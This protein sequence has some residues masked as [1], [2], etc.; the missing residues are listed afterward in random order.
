MIIG[1]K[2]EALTP[3]IILDTLRHQ[4]EQ[5][6]DYFTIHAGV[7]RAHLPLLRSRL[8]GIVSRGGS[9]LAKWMIHHGQENP[10]YTLFDEICQIMRRYDVSFSLGD[11]LRPGGL[12]DASDAA[13]FAELATLGELTER[14]WRNGCQVMVARSV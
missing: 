6:V 3:Q 12:G 11:G 14:A 2:I 10:M 5:G 7:L 8:F 9:L 13:Q 4:A 1:R